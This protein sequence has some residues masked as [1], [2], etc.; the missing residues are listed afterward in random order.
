MGSRMAATL[1]RAGF[2][3]TVWNRTRSKAESFAASVANGARV[4]V[5]DT[6]ASAAA[7]SDIVVTMVVDGDQVA[8]VLLGENGVA[9]GA[10]P[11]TLCIDCST[12]GPTATR[13]I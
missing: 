9:S 8:S 4:A 10:R 3:V 1:V 12:I 2:E 6:P 13:S 5:A 7:Q 11:G